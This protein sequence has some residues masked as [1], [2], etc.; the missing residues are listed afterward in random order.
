MKHERIVEILED[1]LS[2]PTGFGTVGIIGI[3]EAAT[4]I[5]EQLEPE[6]E[7]C[8]CD[9]DHICGI[10]WERKGFRF[11]GGELTPP[12]Q[13]PSE[14]VISDLIHDAMLRNY[15]SKQLAK[16]IMELLNR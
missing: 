13:Q 14:G 5:L 12:P 1:K 3:R 9:S 8:N 10:C 2:A 6:G 16:K 11:I 15:N 4:L 7:I